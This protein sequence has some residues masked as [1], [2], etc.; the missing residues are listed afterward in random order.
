MLLLAGGGYASRLDA[1]AHS[2]LIATT[3]TVTSPSQSTTTA[4]AGIPAIS[5]VVALP[6]A[7]TPSTAAPAM[8]APTR[9]SAELA[10]LAPST[11]ATPEPVPGQVALAPFD[12]ALAAELQRMLDATVADG[13]IPGVVLAVQVPGYQSWM[14][15][16]GIADRRTAQPMQPATLIRIG[17]LSKMFTAVVVLQLAEERKIELDAPIASWLSELV[18]N[19]DSITVRQLLQHTSGL[20]DYLEDR[21]FVNHT[22]REPERIWEPG[23]LVDYATEFPLAFQP[24]AEGAWN[25]SSTNYVLLGM[26]VERVTGNTLAQEQRQRIFDP[27]GLNQTFAA[28]DETIQGVQARGYSNSI[29]QTDAPMSFVVG[30][31]N[32]VSTAAD[33]QRFVQALLSGELLKPD[34]LAMMKQFV[35]G[36]GRYKMPELEYGLGL[37][38]NRLPVGPG[39]DGQPRQAEASTVLGHIGGYGG[40]RAAVWFAP[41]SGISIAL[42]VNQA[43][44]D[45]N[46]LATQVFDA[47]LTQQG[48]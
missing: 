9:S 3:A 16:S 47:I 29:D 22:Y 21:T 44:T 31:A 19:G 23:E 25:Y 15:A 17:S 41:A 45:P 6:L 43:A 32:I 20:Y 5:T 10:A 33:V 4:T 34:T 18:P 28:P 26:I 39:P 1:R 38:R 14:G 11:T 35:N 7:G 27:L 36:K 42:G 40:F 8:V 2:G 24:G 48:R 13:A 46:T 30:T 37:M 12:P